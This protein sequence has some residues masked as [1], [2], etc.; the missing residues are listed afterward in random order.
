MRTSLICLLI[1][2]LF[3][4]SGCGKDDPSSSTPKTSAPPPLVL[5]PVVETP[6]AL[7]DVRVTLSP[8]A[9]R[10]GDDLTAVISGTKGGISYQWTRNGELLQEESNRLPAHSAVK[11]DTVSVSVHAENGTTAASVQIVNTPPEIISLPFEDPYISAGREIRVNPEGVDP[12]GDELTYRYVWTLNGEDLFF[13]EGASLPPDR[14]KKGDRIA[15]KVIPNDGDDDG[16]PFQGAEFTVPNSPPYFVSEPPRDF[17]GHEY[18]YRP[19][20]SDPD[21]D[22]LAYRLESGPDGMEIDEVTGEIRWA[23]SPADA[24]EHLIRIVVED[25]EG[26]S[27]VQEYALA[28]SISQ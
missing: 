6:S 14:F 21:D 16:E 28:L 7:G 11:G 20:V 2:S 19:V 23:I 9:P 13:E 15:L 25:S 27:A 3:S 24:G 12:D 4:L 5:S 1:L 26:M 22:P 17:L 8:E 18:L 10:A